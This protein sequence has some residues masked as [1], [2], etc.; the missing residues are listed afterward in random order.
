MNRRNFRLFGALTLI[1]VCVF[2]S[3]CGRQEP[4]DDGV[5]KIVL[6]AAA[7]SHGEGHH[8]W[9]QDAEFIKQCLLEA[10]NVE[11][12]TIEIHN[13]G[14]PKNPRDLDD[15]DAIVFLTDQSANYGWTLEALN[16]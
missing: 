3:S 2:L 6:L 10:P 5:D 12:L 11:D 8:D 9:D 13:N 14:W 4:A 15:A 1:L 7:P 16:D